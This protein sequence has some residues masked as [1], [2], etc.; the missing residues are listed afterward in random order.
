MGD[1]IFQKSKS[2]TKVLGKVKRVSRYGMHTLI[3]F[4]CLLPRVTLLICLEKLF[5]CMG[6]V[7][8]NELTIVT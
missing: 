5:L 1:L 3:M 4:V 6:E 2:A 8:A 7:A